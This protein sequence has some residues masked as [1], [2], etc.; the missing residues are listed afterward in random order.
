MK[1]LLVMLALLGCC[2]VCNGKEER[3]TNFAEDSDLRYYLDL[4]SVVSLPDNVYIFWLKSTAKDKE[5]FKRE[6][7]LNDLSYIFTN[8]ELDCAVSSYRI[9]GT[10]MFDKRR[11]EIG[12]ILPA[13]GETPFEP[14]PP[15]SMLE[16][17][18]DEICA[19]EESAARVPEPDERE[20]AA[21]T[22]PDAPSVPDSTVAPAVPAQAPSTM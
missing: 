9:R 2:S 3:W 4:K 13:A 19:E 17:A 10:I 8:Y 6:Y 7:N 12:K 20:V 1:T 5:Y 21:P 11:K 22:Q 16:L 14:V 18:Q 15:E